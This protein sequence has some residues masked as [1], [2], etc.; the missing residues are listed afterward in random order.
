[1]AQ[2]RG[3]GGI[4]KTQIEEIKDRVNIE[5]IVKRYVKLKPVGKNLFG[6][7]PFHSEKTPSF[8]VNPELNIFKCY[9]CG[10]AGDV[11]TFL[12][13]IESLEF[14]E[15]LEVL[16]KEA[17]ITLEQTQASRSSS[18]AYIKAKRIHEL[19]AKYY[20]YLLKK[21][22]IGSAARSYLKKRSLPETAVEEFGIGYS[23]SISAKTSLSSF[24]KKEGFTDQDL[25]RFGISSRKGQRTVDRFVDRIMFPIYDTTGKVL[26]FSGRVF[27]LNDA[28]P[29]YLNTPETILFQKRKNLYG[30]YQSKR[31]I[32]ESDLAIIVEG[33]TDV[34]SSWIHGT[35]NIVAPLGTGTTTD[36]LKKLKRYSSNLAISYDKDLAGE[37]AHKRLVSLAFENGFS[38]YSV[39]IPYG[40]DADE[41][42]RHDPKLWEK[43]VSER[44]PSISYFLDILSERY[45]IKTLDGKRKLLDEIT[46]LLRSISDDVIL[47]HHLKELNLLTDIPQDVLSERV[48]HTTGVYTPVEREEAAVKPPDTLSHETYLLALLLQF[49]EVLSW[50]SEKIPEEDIHDPSVRSIAESLINAYKTQDTAQTSSFI[51]TLP[52]T[53]Q[54]FAKDLSLRPLWTVDPTQDQ[55]TDEINTT[56]RNIKEH[57][58][59]D[60]IS[61]LRK[62]LAIAEQRGDTKKSNDILNTISNKLKELEA[63]EV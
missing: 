1:M 19:A 35:K 28:R 40:N 3:R 15:A 61:S 38:V 53:E 49:P 20:Q 57:G 29:K 16:A 34:I 59:R 41:T 54:E 23:P 12:Q 37:N 30:L 22:A 48:A 7:C 2:T 51:E 45:D 6:V 42:I 55:L 32:R 46:P 39:E 31:A 11:I 13:K 17:G 18:D 26:G 10:E 8:S 58:L 4:S 63:L 21:H 5:D 56:I 27:R 44:K 47:D 25:I 52:N 24:L 62:D 60:E 43:A 33:Q 50:V 14:H 36:Q 9:G